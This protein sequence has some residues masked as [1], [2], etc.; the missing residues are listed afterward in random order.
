MK[1]RTIRIRSSLGAEFNSEVEIKGEKYFVQ[2]E[3]GGKRNPVIQTRVYLKG[4]IIYTREADYRDVMNEPDSERKTEELM[5]KQHRLALGLLRAD[6]KRLER[7]PTDYLEEVRSLIDGKEEGKAL[8]VVN[9]A[10][11]QHPDNPFLLSY[12]GFLEAAVNRKFR[13]GIRVCNASLEAL[14]KKV[15]FGEEFFY[16]LL[17]LNLGKAYLAAGKKREAF[18]AFNRGLDVDQGNSELRNMLKGLGIRR[19]PPLPFLKRSNI[20]NKCLGMLRQRLGR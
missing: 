9:E 4:R 20:L 5:K 17:Y 11:E 2:T 6:K 8:A 19:R 1:D 7:S 3:A 12:C 16:P 10:L 14:K 18:N 15:P 13:E